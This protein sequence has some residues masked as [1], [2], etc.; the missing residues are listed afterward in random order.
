[1]NGTKA[2]LAPSLYATLHPL[3]TSDC[4]QAACSSIGKSRT[5]EAAENKRRRKNKKQNAQQRGKN[6]MK[7][8]KIWAGKT[9]CNCAGVISLI[10]ETTG[11]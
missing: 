5:V 7:R 9:G 3:P 10:P 1:M 2:S 4:V 6:G 11:V 8:S